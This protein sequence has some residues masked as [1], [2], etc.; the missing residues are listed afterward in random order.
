MDEK[1]M[2]A[3]MAEVT[4][5]AAEALAVLTTAVAAQCNAAR[6]ASDL[7]GFAEGRRYP[8]ETSEMSRGIVH[9]LAEAAERVAEI[10]SRG[11]KH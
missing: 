11:T 2:A 6:L 1:F 5:V 10:Q 9:K 4:Q 8:I 7:R 3:A